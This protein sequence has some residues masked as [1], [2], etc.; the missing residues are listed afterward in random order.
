MNSKVGNLAR[1]PRKFFVLERAALFMNKARVKSKKFA[2]KPTQSKSKFSSCL[3][4]MSFVDTISFCCLFLF[5]I[6]YN[7]RGLKL[8]FVFFGFFCNRCNI[9]APL[10]KI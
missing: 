2:A 3:G 10:C 4:I 7:Q 6:S 1:R 8:I 5:G 9:V